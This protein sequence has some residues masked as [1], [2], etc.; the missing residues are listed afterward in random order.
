MSDSRLE[1]GALLDV[2]LYDRSRAVQASYLRHVG[3]L[4]IPPLRALIVGRQIT[5]YHCLPW[6]FSDA[7]HGLSE[8]QH[9]ALAVSGLL[10][11][12]HLLLVD[13]MIDRDDDFSATTL[14]AANALHERSL[15]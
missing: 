12:G 1:L 10:Y 3:E 15:V 8:H 5:L 7:L 6:M 4:G 14:L 11:F 13:R 9:Q 2:E